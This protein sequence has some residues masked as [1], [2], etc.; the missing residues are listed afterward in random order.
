MQLTINFYWTLWTHTPI[1]AFNVISWI[2]WAARH[3][4]MFGIRMHFVVQCY[5][6]EMSATQ[7]P[8]HI[9]NIFHLCFICIRYRERMT[10]KSANETINCRCVTPNKRRHSRN[11]TILAMFWASL[12]NNSTHLC[13]HTNFALF[14]LTLPSTGYIIVLYASSN[15][16]FIVLYCVRRRKRF[17]VCVCMCVGSNAKKS[18]AH[19]ATH[20]LQNT[21]KYSRPRQCSTFIWRLI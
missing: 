2:I 14:I 7:N 10:W 12:K 11:A 9:D 20:S 21:H 1:P 4:S 19:H 17:C 3:G 5:C 18:N 15:A 8:C 16:Y 6:F 13:T